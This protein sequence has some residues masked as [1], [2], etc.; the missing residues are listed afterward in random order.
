MSEIIR[1]KQKLV[2]TAIA[3]GDITE[4]NKWAKIT[5]LCEVSVRFSMHE[6]IELTASPIGKDAFINATIAAIASSHR[7]EQSEVILAL[8]KIVTKFANLP[9]HNFDGRNNL[10]RKLAKN[11][12]VAIN[13]PELIDTIMNEAQ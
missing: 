4:E 9:D 12:E 1:Q 2:E 8:L 5:E 3:N 11:V 6:M 7:Y 13:N 10:T